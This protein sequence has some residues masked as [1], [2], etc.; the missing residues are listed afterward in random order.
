[1]EHKNNTI[2]LEPPFESMNKLTVAVGKF[3]AKLDNVQI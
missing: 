2:D 1:M 3:M